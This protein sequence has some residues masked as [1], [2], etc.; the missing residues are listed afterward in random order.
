ML[1][2]PNT[3]TLQ[4]CQFLVLI[5]LCVGSSRL[6][7]QLPSASQESPVSYQAKQFTLQHGLPDNFVNALLQDRYG[8]IWIGTT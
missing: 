1:L 5:L 8:F 3:C 2:A 4:R 6:S 7:A